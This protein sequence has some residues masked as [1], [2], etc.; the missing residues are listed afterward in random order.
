MGD[1]K[2]GFVEIYTGN[3]KGKTTAAVGLAVR[4]AGNKFTVSMVQLLKGGPTGELESAEKLKPYFNI[5]RF[6]KPRDFFWN[7][8]DAEKEELQ[9]DID[10]AYDFC[11]DQLINH[12][13]DILIIDEIMG[14]LSNKLITEEQVVK[15]IEAK[16]YDVELVMT[17]RDVPHSIVEKADLVTE[18]KEIKHYFEEG[19]PARKGIEF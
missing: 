18:M 4:A 14:A 3:G 12:K 5:Y 6:E 9:K 15:L 13:C 2:K 8:N 17:G 11:M 19:V 10:K 1:L 7:L 16:P